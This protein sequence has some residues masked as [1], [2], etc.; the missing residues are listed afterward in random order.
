MKKFLSLILRREVLGTLGLLALSALVWWVGPLIAIGSARPL[1]GVLARV[2][3]LVV[4]WALWLGSLGWRAW[5]RR[6]AHTALL[7]GLS[8][9]P[10]AADREAQVLAQRFDEAVGKLK[11]A[12]AAQGRGGNPLYDLPWYVFIGAPGFCRAG[13]AAGA[14]TS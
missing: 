2:L 6:Q 14:V 5:K 1:D 9:G 13:S 7:Q 10:S 4:L 12:T 8:A 3:V 11:S